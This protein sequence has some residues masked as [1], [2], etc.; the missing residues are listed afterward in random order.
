MEGLHRWG[1]IIEIR[2]VLRSQAYHPLAG[3]LS[4]INVL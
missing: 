3:T 4:I 1:K 2:G